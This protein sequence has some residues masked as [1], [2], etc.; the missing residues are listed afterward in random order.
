MHL[1]V[2][3]I[4]IYMQCFLSVMFFPKCS[5]CLW[6]FCIVIVVVS[7]DNIQD[8]LPENTPSNRFFKHVF[9][10]LDDG[11]V[12]SLALVLQKAYLNLCKE[13]HGCPRAEMELEDIFRLKFND[14]ELSQSKMRRMGLLLQRLF[15]FDERVE[16]EFE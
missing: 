6:I 5:M 14:I 13:L 15:A 8:M 10:R 12:K 16:S 7:G 4:Y 11:D 2:R 9:T 3:L 1:C